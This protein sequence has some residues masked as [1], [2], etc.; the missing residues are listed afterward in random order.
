[1][2]SSSISPP[3]PSTPPSLNHQN[4]YL[5]LRDLPWILAI[6]LIVLM[7]AMGLNWRRPEPESARRRQNGGGEKKNDEASIAFT[8]QSLSAK[9][10]AICLE[11]MKCGEECR[12]LAKCG[13]E[14]HKTCVDLWLTRDKHCPLCRG[15]IRGRSVRESSLDHVV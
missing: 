9:S 7:T 8:C 11:D 1:M 4:F 2:F 3:S 13:H 14:Y 6:A 10:C 5:F 15:S 12:R